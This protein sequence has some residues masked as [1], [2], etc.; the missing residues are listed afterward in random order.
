MLSPDEK[1]LRHQRASQ[2]R[3]LRQRS[4]QKVRQC[5][6]PRR[7]NPKKDV[8]DNSAGATLIACPAVLDFESAPC[9]STEFFDELERTLTKA[10]VG[11]VVDHRPLANLSPAAALVLIAYLFRIHRRRPN[12][13]LFV[14]IPT[15]AEPRDLLGLIG[16]Y[17]YFKKVAWNRPQSA[18]RH[19]LAHKRG[20]LVMPE[21]AKELC[22]HLQTHGK[23]ST[24]K[25][26]AAL[27]EG[28]ANATEWGYGEKESGYRSW[29]LL[30]YRDEITKEM[31]YSFYDQGVGIPKSIRTRF[32]DM[33][34]GLRPSGSE[35]IEIAV[36][37]GR[38]S[39]TKNKG[40]GS[41]LP[42][43]LSFVEEG[44]DGQL[45]IFS[46]ESRCVFKHGDKT[47]KD[48][49]NIGLRGTLISWSFSPP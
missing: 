15:R 13:P 26:Y 8:P 2:Q 48:E 28:M 3:T 36:R 43:L 1:R 30:G 49:Y 47:R 22:A 24:Q 34:P 31:A 23:L 10:K 39:R 11:V 27:V 45:L 42:T 5:R 33:L 37:E 32:F 20:E 41:G 38:Y 9:E 25:F 17:D 12:L 14:Y 21:Y 35:L 40:R 18:Q 44:T 46:N 4:K 29:W 6:G 19:Y 16:Y 7:V